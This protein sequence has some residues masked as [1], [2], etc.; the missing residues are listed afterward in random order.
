MKQKK[1]MDIEELSEYI[2]STPSSIYS[3]KCR[4]QIPHIK[5]GR[6][7]IFDRETIDE[8]ITNGGK[9]I[10]KVNIPQIKIRA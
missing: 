1:Y 5:I 10:P 8:W 9:L 2:S 6:R 3:K 4:N 7:L